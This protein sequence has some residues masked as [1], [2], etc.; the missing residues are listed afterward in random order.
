MECFARSPFALRQGR[1]GSEGVRGILD[2]LRHAPFTAIKPER[3]AN[4][5]GSI[6]NAWGVV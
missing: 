3:E 6:V 5:K 1:K 2:F 4:E